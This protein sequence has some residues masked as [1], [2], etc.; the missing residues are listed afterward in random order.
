VDYYK[1]KCNGKFQTIIPQNFSKTTGEY[2]EKISKQYT[3]S[4]KDRIIV[5]DDLPLFDLRLPQPEINLHTVRFDPPTTEVQSMVKY[6]EIK[7]AF[8]TLSIV[9]PQ[10]PQSPRRHSSLEEEAKNQ[11]SL[12]V[13]P[14][15]QCLVFIADNA[16]LMDVS[17]NGLVA[18]RINRILVE[19]ATIFFNKAISFVPCFK[20]SDSEDVILFASPNIKLHVDNAGQFCSDYYGMKHEL[21]ECIGSHEVFVDLND[22]HVFKEFPLSKLLT[23]SKTVVCVHEFYFPFHFAMFHFRLQ[24]LSHLTFLHFSSLFF[25]FLHFSSLFSFFSQLLS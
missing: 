16:L 23:E 2:L 9:V 12:S 7:N 22:D 10:S 5:Y 4:E 6:V 24:S 21:I 11:E 15:Q 3:F 25:T 8:Q 19:I 13:S 17:S 18:I 14:Q 1:V 20:Y